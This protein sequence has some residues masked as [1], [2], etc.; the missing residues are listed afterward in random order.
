[1]GLQEELS[2]TEGRLLATLSWLLLMVLFAVRVST[3]GAMTQEDDVFVSGGKLGL[4]LRHIKWWRNGKQSG[5]GRR[6]DGA[7]LRREGRYGIPF[8]ESG[9]SWRDRA[10]AVILSAKS[11]GVLLLGTERGYKGAAAKFNASLESCGFLIRADGEVSTSHSGRKTCACASSALGVSLEVL[12]EWLL[13]LETATVDTYAK[14]D[15]NFELVW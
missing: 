8:V 10:V 13:F 3:L 5:T 1:M 4:V 11:H 6:C 14:G 7:G 2:A 15:A 9:S 12:R